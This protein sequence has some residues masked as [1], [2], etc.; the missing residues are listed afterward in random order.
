MSSLTDI[1]FLLLIF[2][3]LTSSM[4]IPNALNLKLPSSTGSSESVT[5]PNKLVIQANGNYIYNGSRVAKESLNQ[6]ILQLAR[7]GKSLTIAPHPKTE[8]QFVVAVMDMAFKHK[9]NTVLA[10]PDN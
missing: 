8:N 4:V 7:S 1:I 3:M 10:E 9:V 2:F 5:R 6:Q